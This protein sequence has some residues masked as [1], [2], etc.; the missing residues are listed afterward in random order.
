MASG[1]GDFNAHTT[2][3]NGLSE[4]SVGRTVVLGG[5]LLNNTTVTTGAFT[6]T[7]ASSLSSFNFVSPGNTGFGTATPE[8]YVHIQNTTANACTLLTQSYSSAAGWI[9]QRKASG[10]FAAPLALVNGAQ[11]GGMSV[12]GYNGTAYA[13]CGF[14][15]FG[16]SEA[17]TPTAK[18]TVFVLSTVAVGTVATVQRIRTDLNGN[19]ILGTAT[20]TTSS[21]LIQGSIAYTRGSPPSNITLNATMHVTIFRGGAAT[22]F[23]PDPAT[24]PDR[25]YRIINHGTGNTTFDRPITIALGVTITTLGNAA[26]SNNMEIMSDGLV[27][28]RIGI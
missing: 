11:I 4:T 17:H 27:W 8:A 1:T 21:N 22:C 14:F 5:P 7:L 26:G 24:C 16:A 6:F 19:V 18:G 23:L 12:F 2:A 9:E 13:Q 28:R 25:V 10:T 20:T 3:E 15:V